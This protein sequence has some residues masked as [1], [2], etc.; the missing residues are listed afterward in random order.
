MKNYILSLLV[1]FLLVSCTSTLPKSKVFN[2]L[3]TDGVY[4]EKVPR[5]NG[6]KL[7]L[8]FYN[9]STTSKSKMRV[10][11]SGLNLAMPRIITQSK[12]DTSFI[13]SSNRNA[14]QYRVTKGRMGISMIHNLSDFVFIKK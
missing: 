6:N 9:P 1:L 13:V 3:R 4:V 14:I 12:Y 2:T 5:A 7:K 10:L 11:I 8:K